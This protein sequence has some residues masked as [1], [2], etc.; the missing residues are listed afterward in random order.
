QQ[1]LEPRGHTCDVLPTEDPIAPLEARTRICQQV[2]AIRVKDRAEPV[3]VP[4]NRASNIEG[5]P[6]RPYGDD[7]AGLCPVLKAEDM[8]Y[9]LDHPVQL[10]GLKKHTQLQL[11]MA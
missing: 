5:H 7:Q 9:A 6:V 2:L 4:K 11:R 10:P 3:E 8:H 1:G